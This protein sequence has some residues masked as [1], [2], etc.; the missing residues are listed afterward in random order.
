MHRPDYAGAQHYALTRLERELADNLLY[1]SLAHTRD[2]IIPAVKRLAK[3]EGITGD[4]FQLLLTA[5]SFHDLGFILQQKDHE[6]V[7]AQFARD[8]LPRFGFSPAQIEAICGMILATRVPQN[9]HTRLEEILADADLDVLGRDDFW[10]RNGL[11]RAE[12]GHFGQTPTDAQWYAGQFK[13]MESHHY[14]TQAA[15]TLREAQKHKNMQEL[16]ARLAAQ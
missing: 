13:F 9:P 14:F 3:L 4:D 11:L 8:E 10:T 7:G 15:R 12:L 1:H 5:A 6:M 16:V 2:D